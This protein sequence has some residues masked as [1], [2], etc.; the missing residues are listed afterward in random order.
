VARFGRDGVAL[1]A[2]DADVSQPE[3]H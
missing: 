3:L 2:S 1:A